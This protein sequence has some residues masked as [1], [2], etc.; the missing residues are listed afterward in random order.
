MPTC[1]VKCVM[2]L[3]GRVIREWEEETEEFKNE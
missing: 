1:K 3:N 2:L